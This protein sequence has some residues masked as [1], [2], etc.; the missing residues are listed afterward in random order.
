MRRRNLALFVLAAVVL[1][2]LATWFASARIHSPA[3]IAARTA[4]PVPSPILVPVEQRVLATKIVSRGTGHYGSPRHLAIAPS[5]LKAGYQVVTTLPRV[6]AVVDE[7]A[8]LLTISGRP[9]FLLDGPQPAYR[10][11]G[12]G[13]S[14]P[15][16]KQLETALKRLGLDPGRVDDS[17]DSS[18]ADAVAALYRRHGF[19]PVIAT[20]S[21]LRDVRPIQAELVEGARAQG[22]IQL[23][24]DEVI[25]VPSTPLRVTQLR[26]GL[27]APADRPLVTVTN[28]IVAVN[29]TLPVEQAGV[30]KTGARVLIDEAALG[31]NATGKVSMVAERPGTHGVDGFHVFFQVV[32][33]DPPPAL[34]G[35]SVRLTIP[36]KTTRRAQLAVPVSAVSLGPDGASRVQRSVDGKLSF[37]PVEPG[38]SAD[39]YVAV[40]PRGELAAGDLVVVGFDNRETTGE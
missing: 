17:Y 28:S 32:V 2:S 6:G 36:I 34:V 14:G 7:G 39:G 26:V 5:A 37:V 22:G 4:P 33:D 1:S 31:I 18:T 35:A 11:L 13:M 3:E 38:L 10:D 30:V 25:F 20:E 29:A 23:P 8:V 12:P 15:D 16:V 40:T 21:E 9:A 19:E 24:A 27:G